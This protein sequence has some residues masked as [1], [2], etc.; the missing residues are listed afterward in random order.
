MREIT[1][2]KEQFINDL[3]VFANNWVD[4]VNNV[5]LKHID[6]LYKDESVKYI[7]SLYVKD[8]E[9]VQKFNEHYLL[10]AYK[11]ERTEVDKFKVF[12]DWANSALYELCYKRY[13]KENENV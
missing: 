1:K 3:Q 6:D 5:I 10:E 7:L 9:K 4:E 11:F 12:Y 8:K 13:V 2:E